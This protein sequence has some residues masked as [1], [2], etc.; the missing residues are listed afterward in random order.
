MA[1]VQRGSAVA[2]LFVAGGGAL[3]GGMTA[4]VL[5]AFQLL[6][7]IAWWVWWAISARISFFGSTPDP[8][9][10]PV[11]DF[12][13]PGILFVGGV[14]VLLLGWV[15][16]I[17]AATLAW[18]DRRDRTLRA[19]DLTEDAER[20][21]TGSEASIRQP[22]GQEKSLRDGEI[23]EASQCTPSDLNREPTD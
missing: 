11:F 5:N 12:L 10:M 13:R 17:R 18:P 19:G 8:A 14:L 22:A 2:G 4:A 9:P 1:S 7:G 21:L 15:L 16:I 3:V 20:L 23:S 6:G